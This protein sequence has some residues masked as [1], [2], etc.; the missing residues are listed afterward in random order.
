MV[1]ALYEG[2][3]LLDGALAGEIF[4]PGASKLDQLGGGCGVLQQSLAGGL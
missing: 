1:D 3:K 4:G 2:D